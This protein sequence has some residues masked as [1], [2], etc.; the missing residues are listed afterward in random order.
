MPEQGIASVLAA[1]PLAAVVVGEDARILGAN[2]RASDL[3]GRA[4]VG[5]HFMTAL[6]Q[7]EV[8]DAIEATL[9]DHQPRTATYLSSD[10]GRDNSYAMSL[11]FIDMASTRGVLLCFEDTSEKEQASQMR[12]DFVA[13]VSHELRTPLTALMGFIETLQGPARRDDSA[14]DRFLGIMQSE[15]A[16]MERLVRDLLSLSRVESEERVRVKD[17]VD[18][19]RIIGSV[20]HTLRPLAK[21]RDCEI[22]FEPPEGV[23]VPG[24]SDQLQQVFTNLIENAIKYGGR[25][26]KITIT[27]DAA[28][29][30]TSL[31]VPAVIAQVR[32][33]GPGIDPL[34]IPR[35]TERFY[36]V[37]THRSREMG[38]TGL[39]LAI[40]KHIVNRHRGRLRIQSVPGQGSEFSVVLPRWI[41]PE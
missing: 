1:L 7:P 10:A 19:G 41:A 16:R 24:N 26:N 20:L 2:T 12:R 27:L 23:L 39:G 15:A 32:D 28:P 6:R 31:R 14:I 3:L 18:L 40:V 17:P 9:A 25:G 35:L 36:R 38:G 37:D 34:H 11:G 8:T 30:E 4:I 33:Q 22:A 13:N 29:P 21:E 5:R